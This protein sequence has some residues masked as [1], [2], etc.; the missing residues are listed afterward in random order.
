[1]INFNPL[2]HQGRERWAMQD[3]LFKERSIFINT[4]INDEM[5]LAICQQLLVLQNLGKDN[6]ITLYISS[7]GGSVSSGFSIV[8]T[9]RSLQC[10]VDTLVMGHAESCGALILASGTGTRKAMRSARIMI[11]RLSYESKGNIQDQVIQ[12]NESKRMD[13]ILNEMLS[14]FCGKTVKELIAAQTR[15]NYFDA[16]EAKKFG[17]IDEVIPWKS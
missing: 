17:L 9:I 6:S 16:E 15:D 13:T 11:H 3:M 10:K 8:D 1:M 12:I 2:V 4:D 14:T 5:A 7:P